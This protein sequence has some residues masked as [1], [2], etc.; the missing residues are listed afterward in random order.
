[1]LIGDTREEENDA[2]IFKIGRVIK[3]KKDFELKKP[4]NNPDYLDLS[5]K[6]KR[7]RT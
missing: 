1:M 3:W 5:M 2:D 6:I 7:I 4:N